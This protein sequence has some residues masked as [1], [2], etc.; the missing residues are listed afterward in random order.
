MFCLDQMTSQTSC[1][2]VIQVTSWRDSFQGVQEIP[3]PKEKIHP[4]IKRLD[5]ATQPTSRATGAGGTTPSIVSH[6]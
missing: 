1:L 6:Q 2:G 5:I 4:R 3:T